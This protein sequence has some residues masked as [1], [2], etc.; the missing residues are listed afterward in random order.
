M[1]IYTCCIKYYNAYALPIR[2]DM[3]Y[4]QSIAP[5]ITSLVH[6]VTLPVLKKEHPSTS[7][8]ILEI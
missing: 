1:G 5:E 3:Y 7:Y 8:M 2:N 6:N 4:Y